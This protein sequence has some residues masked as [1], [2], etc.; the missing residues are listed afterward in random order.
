MRR[1]NHQMQVV[2]VTSYEE[3]QDYL[4]L[5]PDEFANLFNTMLINV[6]SFFRDADSWAH[7]RGEILPPLLEQKAPADPDLECRVRHR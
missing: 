6:T 2:Q 7:L 3:Y 5:H 1:V 4:E